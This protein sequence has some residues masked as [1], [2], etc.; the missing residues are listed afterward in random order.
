L[1]IIPP[2]NPILFNRLFAKELIIMIDSVKVML[3]N[4]GM[5]F[6]YRCDDRMLWSDTARQVPYLPVVYS[7]ESIDYQFCY[8]VGHGGEWHDMSIVITWSNKPVAIWPLSVAVKD[9]RPKIDSQGLPLLPPLFV[10]DCPATSRKKISKLCFELAKN[11]AA[12]VGVDS[13]CS[14]ESFIQEWGMSDWHVEAMQHGAGS[15][16]QHEVYVDLSPDLSGIKAHF[17]KRYKSLINT[18]LRMWTV[19]LLDSDDKKIWQQFRD[20]HFMV[21]GR[22]TRSDESWDIQLEHIANKSAFLIYLTDDKDTMVGGGLFYQTKDE[23]LYAVGAYDRSLFDKPIGHV[24]QHRAIEEFK[25]R[26]VRWYKVGLRP[27]ATDTPQ[28]TEKEVSIAEFKHGFASHVFP[29]YKL[30]FEQD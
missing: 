13:W 25:K 22:K 8:Q 5:E 30:H 23:G 21:A 14:N 15:S 24:V 1:L 29:L 6:T 18:G 19:K 2:G 27:Y 10:A 20:L 16:M 12:H 11:I 4:S 7:H 17:R 28:P 9:G 26:G 3:D